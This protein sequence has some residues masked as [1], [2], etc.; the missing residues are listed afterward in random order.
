[1]RLLRRWYHTGAPDDAVKRDGYFSSPLT[2]D[3]L[4]T[5]W[6]EGKD[7][8]VTDNSVP[9]LHYALK[10]ALLREELFDSDDITVP[11]SVQE[12]R[13]Q[14]RLL[15]QYE[16]IICAAPLLLETLS[17]NYQQSEKDIACQQHIVMD[18]AEYGE[19]LHEITIFLPRQRTDG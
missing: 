19:A 15:Q 17:I 13:Y 16:D 4:L 14:A 9:S 12:Y 1:P 8:I 18:Y 7:R 2:S 3:S 6:Q 10:G 5:R 11:F